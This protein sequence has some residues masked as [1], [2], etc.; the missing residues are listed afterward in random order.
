MEGMSE[1]RREVWVIEHPKGMGVVIDAIYDTEEEARADLERRLA[2]WSIR[3]L[4]V[5]WEMAL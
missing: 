1:R 2:G 3:R 5:P 4:E